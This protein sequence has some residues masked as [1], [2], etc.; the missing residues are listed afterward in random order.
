VFADTGDVME[1]ATVSQ[2][3]TIAS[4]FAGVPSPEPLAE[5]VPLDGA[6]SA[7]FGGNGRPTCL[8]MM[9]SLLLHQIIAG[10]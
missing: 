8:G 4:R 7:G 9:R 6:A 2:S 10:V 1:G 5:Q 3:R